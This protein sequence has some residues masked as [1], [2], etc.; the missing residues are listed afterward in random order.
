MEGSNEQQTMT[1]SSPPHVGLKSSFSIR[2]I[3]PEA[4]SG[5]PVPSVSQSASPEVAHIEDSDETSDLD[6]TGTQ[7]PPLDCSRNATSNSPSGEKNS[8]EQTNDKKEPV[9]PPYSYNALIMM[10]IRHSP[11]KRLTLNGIYEYIMNRFP[12]YENNKQGWQNSIRHNLSLN[13]CFIKVPRHYDDPGK[14]NYWMLDPSSD[15]VFIGGATGKLRRRNTA[16]S[17][18]RMAAFKRNIVLSGLYSPQ[19]V[20]PT[21]P[22]SLYNLPYFHR[23]VVYPT[24]AGYTNPSGYTNNLLP[25]ATTTPA[26]LPCKPQ[27]LPAVT[28]TH[29][30]FSVERLL[31]APPGYTTG[32]PV[33]GMPGSGNPYDFYSTLRS[34]AVHQQHPAVMFSQHP[35]FHLNQ[36][37]SVLSQPAS[38]TA[39]PGSS[40][41]PISPHSSPITVSN[42]IQPSRSL[43]HS[44]PQLLLKPITVLT[45]R[46]S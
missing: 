10:A 40:P 21:W 31:Q 8:K 28:R 44:P 2:N 5:T 7:T 25:G 23:S 13:K 42:S 37:P 24:T 35:R 46:Q 33:P 27:P 45:G 14:G 41:E 15:D 32:I 18:S 29:G 17:R 30:A 36:T 20:P 39:S 4:C 12:Y 34:L 26:N 3:V 16:A 43:P 9:K 38:S 6:V 1:A 11:D 19:Y 22:P